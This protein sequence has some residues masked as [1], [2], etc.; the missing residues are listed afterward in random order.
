MQQID[1]QN[2]DKFADSI[3]LMRSGIGQNVSCVFSD[4]AQHL[5]LLP[6]VD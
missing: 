2:Q 6:I 5:G 4:I 1:L 3:M